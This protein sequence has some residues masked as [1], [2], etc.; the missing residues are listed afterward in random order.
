[1]FLS[2][3]MVPSLVEVHLLDGAEAAVEEPLE[4]VEQEVRPAVGAPQEEVALSRA[5]ALALLLA[6]I[7]VFLVVLCLCPL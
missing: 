4:G 5:A 6:E 1:M 3:G 2:C 7:L